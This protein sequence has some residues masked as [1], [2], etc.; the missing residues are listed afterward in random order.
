L[1]QG[2]DEGQGGGLSQ[3]APGLDFSAR[4]NSID[5]IDY[6]TGIGSVILSIGAQ[7]FACACTRIYAWLQFSTAIDSIDYV[8]AWYQGWEWVPGGDTPH[9]AHS[10]QV[11]AHFLHPL[12]GR[13][14]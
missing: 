10:D 8:P 4:S 3:G 13:Y 7:C 5:Y 6:V 11:W 1:S 9:Y 12:L 14:P 2:A